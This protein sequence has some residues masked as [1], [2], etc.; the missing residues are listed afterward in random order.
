MAGSAGANH[1]QVIDGIGRREDIGVVAIFA[2][3]GRPD[4]THILASSVRT[5]MTATAIVENLIVTEVRW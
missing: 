3:L 2:D 1:I 5:V 4:V